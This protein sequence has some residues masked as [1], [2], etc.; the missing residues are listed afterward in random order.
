MGA[1]GS[2]SDDSNNLWVDMS[3][4]RVERCIGRGGFGKVNAVMKLS[5]PGDHTMYA[6][7]ALEKD[8][9]VE[10]NMFDEVHGELDFLRTLRNPNICNGY[11]AFQDNNHLYLVLDLSMGG[12]MHVHI[13]RHREAKNH[14]N[15]E[16]VRYF[17]A[18]L[19]LA[20]DYCHS[21]LIL[22]RDIKPDN[23]L[24]DANGHLRITD[25]GISAKLA[26]ADAK[27]TNS[28]GTLQYMAPEIR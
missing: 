4:F 28:S 20:L 12:D 6:M 7:K 21:K 17:A 15:M 2:K 3:H 8:V 27:C 19:A 23:I 13:D 25:F 11:Y 26:S 1:C 18:S 10:K 5:K 24:V 22:H 9:V 16:E 14:F